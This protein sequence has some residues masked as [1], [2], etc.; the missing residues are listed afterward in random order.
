MELG[1][2]NGHV[3]ETISGLEVVKA[4]NHEEKAIKEFEAVNE[5]LRQVG[6]KAQI[7][8]GFF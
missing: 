7:W 3:E 1:K 2:L 8:S 6:T 5:R 4:F